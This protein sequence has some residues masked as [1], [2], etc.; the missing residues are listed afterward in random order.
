MFADA[1]CLDILFVMR[2]HAYIFKIANT[3]Y[4]GIFNMNIQYMTLELCK[5]V[6]C[7]IFHSL[8]WFPH[9]GFSSANSYLSCRLSSNLTNYTAACTVGMLGADMSL[10]WTD[11]LILKHTLWLR[12]SGNHSNWSSSRYLH[13]STRWSVR[14][15]LRWHW[16]SPSCQEESV[17]WEARQTASLKAGLSPKLWILPKWRNKSL[18]KSSEKTPVEW[19]LQFKWYPAWRPLWCAC[20]RITQP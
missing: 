10:S 13:G 18:K 2:W 11:T 15:C 12:G 6:S 9:E 19:I 5:T 7:F 4:K 3:I 20:M 1:T 14:H 16:C 17:Y 8:P